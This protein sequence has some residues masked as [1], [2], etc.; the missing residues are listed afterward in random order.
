MDFHRHGL[1]TKLGFAALTGNSALAIYRS[2]DDPRAVAFVAG[3]YGGIAL[4]FHFLR[5]FERGEGDGGR[6]RAAVWVLTTLLTAM[7]ASRVAPLMP[8]T[9]GLF[10]YLMAAGTAGTGFWALFLHRH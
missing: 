4:L 6:T 7:F 3:A 9:V 8:P 1:L 5:R 10:V 2:R